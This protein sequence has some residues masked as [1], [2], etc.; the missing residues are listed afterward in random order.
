MA[1]NSKPK[2]NALISL[3]RIDARRDAYGFWKWSGFSYVGE[4]PAKIA[5]YAD[6][7]LL[8]YIRGEGFLTRIK[9]GDLGVEDD[10]R[11]LVI[12]RKESRRPIYAIEY[13]PVR[14]SG[15]LHRN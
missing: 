1:S 10:G 4:V 14:G 3:L 11:N 5:G 6:R 13:E 15:P 9:N 8:D 7:C 2:P 12:V